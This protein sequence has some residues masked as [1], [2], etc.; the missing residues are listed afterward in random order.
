MKLA[1]SLIMALSLP[2]AAQSII[3]DM[4]GQGILPA[5]EGIK[6]AP[7]EDKNMVLHVAGSFLSRH[8]T[9]RPD[10]TAA[11]IFNNGSPCPV[12]FKK[13]VVTRIRFRLVP[14]RDPLKSP[15]RRFIVCLAYEAHREWKPGAT[16]WTDWQTTEF[17]FFPRAIIVEG[18][19]RAW[20]TRRNEPLVKFTPAPGPSILDRLS[21]GLP[22]GIT[23]SR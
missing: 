9:F 10:G 19:D 15:T 14:D 2:A 5:V 12:E 11:A 18:K 22:P 7:E 20:G 23:R 4:L 8:I 3:P 21:E 6:T 1:I 13:L 16:G 17:S